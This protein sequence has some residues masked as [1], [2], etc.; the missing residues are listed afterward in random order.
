MSP[1]TL[2]DPAPARIDEGVR[3]PIHAED[4]RRRGWTYCG[5]RVS[6]RAHAFTIECVVCAEERKR[7]WGL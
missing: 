7:M 5:L 3:K 4:H 6:K 1:A 2:A